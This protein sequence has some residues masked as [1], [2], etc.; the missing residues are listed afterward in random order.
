[1]SEWN[2]GR[3]VRVAA[4]AVYSYYTGNWQVFAAQLL[5]EEGG[6]TGARRRR[7][8]EMEYNAQ[9]KDRLEMFEPLPDA[10]R[11]L[12][13]GRVRYVEGVRRR[14]SSG[15]HD[16]KLTLVV[17]FAGHEI[18]GFEQWYLDE[19]PVTLDGSGWVQEVPWGGSSQVPQ[20]VVGVLNGSG[21]AA[22]TLA[23]PHAGSSLYATWKSGTG[24]AEAQGSLSV[25]V[26]GLTANVSG[27]PAGA[28]ATVFYASVVPTQRVRIRPYLGTSSQNVG[29]D[30]AAEYP[31][32]IT[33]TDRFAGIALAVVDLIYDPDVF[34]QGRPNITAVL[35]GAKCLDP[36]TGATVWT[37]NPAL[38]AYHYARWESGWGLQVA[39]IRAADVIAAANVCDVS[40]VYTLRD[41]SGATSTATLPRFRSG[42]T[43]SAAVGH[44]QAMG[45]LVSAMAG[46]HGWSGG[47]WRLRAGALGSTVATV[48]DAWLVRD[49]SQGR[50]GDEPVISAVQT[51]TR[52]ERH[53]R[54]TGS[55]VDPAQR[56]QLLPFPAVQDDVLVAAKGRRQL[57]VQLQ[58]VNHIAHAQHLASIAIRQAQ[59]GLKLEITAGDQAADLELFDVVAVTLP[60][61]GYAA[62]T[63]E[64]IGWEWG[65]VGPYKLQLA[66][67]TAAMFTP[68][69]ELVGRDPAPD[70]D[71]RAPWDV[72]QITGVS[73]TSG[74]VA[75]TDGSVI[76]R[77]EV[78]WSPAVGE[79][80]RRGGQVEVQ[81]AQATGALPAGEWSS[82]FEPG[83]ATTAIIPGVLRGRFYVVRVRAVQPAPTVVRGP[84]SSPFVL[85]QVTSVRA[86]KT[87][88]Q[89]SAPSTGVQDGDEWIATADGNKRYQREAGAWVAVA[90]GTGA[91]A[92][93]AATEVSEYRAA[94]PFSSASIA[95]SQT[96]T[97]PAGSVSLIL[98]AH[99]TL[100]ATNGT[101][102]AGFARGFFTLAA[103]V[104]GAGPVADAPFS[105]ISLPPGERADQSVI[106]SLVFTSPA[107]GSWP[108]TL[109]WDGTTG[110]TFPA[111]IADVVLSVE[112]IKR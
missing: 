105:R 19:K 82:W 74:S 6:A 41:A 89:A 79:Y 32:K 65:Q 97:V 21:S 94:G 38:H 28:E 36:R 61:Y 20:T 109:F 70:S 31:G 81:Y 75:Q 25:S 27:G 50:A 58:A 91:M 7:N 100:T 112:I 5:R 63:F 9:L 24:D 14:W 66:E 78:T 46:R 90:V 93:G 104:P 107:A 22:L 88:R 83:T 60:K 12:V 1:V 33:S 13:L 95:I 86:A 64:V 77:M 37:E 98:R 85:H 57:D 56:Y 35:R 72:E 8:A 2:L 54:V 92:L 102:G 17:S 110:A 62:K 34:P 53:N 10:P 48:D 23:S 108:V 45:E 39:D 15:T 44:D 47:V 67:V 3:I 29:S 76:G 16:E 52:A 55:C 87:W 101:G 59:A 11:T 42:M 40:T 69:A 103:D 84:W 106:A 68:L 111:Q 51:V 30:L 4:S 73:V 43:I 26:V 99:A 80:V 49:T 18:D 96:L 71:L